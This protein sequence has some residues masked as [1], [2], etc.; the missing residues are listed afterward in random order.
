M[1]KENKIFGLFFPKLKVMQYKY[2]VL[3]KSPY[4]LPFMWIYRM[5]KG[6]FEKTFSI[7]DRLQTLELVKNVKEEDIKRVKDIYKKLGI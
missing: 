4:L 7:K 5:V 1:N 2:P 3:R 6:I